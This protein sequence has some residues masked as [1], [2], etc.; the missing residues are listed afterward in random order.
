[1]QCCNYICHFF[2]VERKIVEEAG[3]FDSS[4]DGSQDYDFILRCIAKSP[5]VTHIP[6]VLYHWRCHPDSTAL[7]P[8]SKLYCYE[9]GKR[10]LELDLA[11]CGEGK[12]KVEMGKYYGMYEVYYPLEEKPLVSVITGKRENIEGLLSVTDFDRFEVVE[13]GE[14]ETTAAVNEAV[15]RAKGAY[16][17]FLPEGIRA[18]R[19]DWI[20]VMAANAARGKIGIVGPKLLNETGHVVSAG[21][22]LGLRATASSL[23]VGNEKESVGYFSRT[24]IQQ[25]IGAVAFEGMMVER[26]VFLALGGFRETF[27]I[28]EAA[29]ELCL[30]VQ[31]NGQEVLFTPFVSLEI[32]DDRFAPGEVHVTD[33]AFEKEYGEMIKNDRYYS[34]NFDKDGAD[35][36]LAFE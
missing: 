14:Q 11:A 19:S 30:K 15:K 18:D 6:K 35:Y 23:F 5:K 4:C 16:C 2:V 3:H 17:I 22:A 36:T 21:M 34:R 29:L 20:T 7:N 33:A 32:T 10:A 25:E 28:N 24:I 27:R 9:A 26:D 12:A 13:Y 8:E 31:K 1:M